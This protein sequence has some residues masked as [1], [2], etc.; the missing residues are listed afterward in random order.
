MEQCR[1]AQF[2]TL[3]LSEK[4]WAYLADLNEQAH[5]R[6]DTIMEQMKEAEA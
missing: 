4:L 1:P 5:E 3:V 6:L 2:S